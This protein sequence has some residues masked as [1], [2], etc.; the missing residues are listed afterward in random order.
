MRATQEQ[1]REF[2]KSL[3]WLDLKDFLTARLEG[4]RDELEGNGKVLGLFDD[5]KDIMWN[6]GRAEEVR[7]LLDL[8]EV[9][10]KNFKI[11]GKEEKPNG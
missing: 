3:I 5:V 6:R 4:I 9:L 8:P 2:E 10:A 7:F 11:F 1:L